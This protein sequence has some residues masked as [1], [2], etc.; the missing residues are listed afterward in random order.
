MYFRLLDVAEKDHRLPP[1]RCQ[2]SPGTA[3]WKYD[4]SGCCRWAAKVSRLPP[5]RATRCSYSRL[6]MMGMY[7]MSRNSMRLDLEAPPIAWVLAQP[8]A[9]GDRIGAGQR[10]CQR[11]V[12][13]PHFGSFWI[14]MRKR[15]ATISRGWPSAETGKIVITWNE[16][17][18]LRPT[19]VAWS[20]CMF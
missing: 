4:R 17:R 20:A 15:A 5:Q 6:A 7:A 13:V 2:L 18:C 11:L 3:K 1:C 19:M 12:H 8:C 10:Q 14:D 16:H 9:I